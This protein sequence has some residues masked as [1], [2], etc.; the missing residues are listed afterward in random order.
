MPMVFKGL[1]GNREVSLGGGGWPVYE[2]VGVIRY[3][4]S[5]KYGYKAGTCRPESVICPFCSHKSDKCKS[6]TYEC[7]S[8]RYLKI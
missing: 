8:R 2:Y 6:K 1:F 3:C 7:T 4:K 5:W